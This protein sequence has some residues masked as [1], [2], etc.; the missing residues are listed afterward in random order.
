[1]T[2]QQEEDA[3]SAKSEEG[4]SITGAKHCEIGS[5]AGLAERGRRA[6]SAYRKGFVADQWR[7]PKLLL[8]TDE[9]YE[10]WA[11]HTKRSRLSFSI[12]EA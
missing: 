10:V 9:R 12:D 1:M 5:G 8:G 4:E 3:G 2:L 11:C 6:L 7:C